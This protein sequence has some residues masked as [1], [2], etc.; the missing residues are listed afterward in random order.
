ML[1]LLD[2]P[3]CLYVTMIV[4]AIYVSRWCCRWS[5]WGV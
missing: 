2:H 4:Y 3:I 5:W 1:I